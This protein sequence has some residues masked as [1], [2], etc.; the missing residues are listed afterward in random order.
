MLRLLPGDS[1]PRI[2]LLGKFVEKEYEKIRKL[3]Q[4]RREY[5]SKVAAVDRSI[6]NDRRTLSTPEQK[7]F[8]DEWLSRRLDA[9]LFCLQ[10]SHSTRLSI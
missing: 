3:I 9:G 4:L 7:D 8:A 6:E 10:V 1:A 2:R 5:A